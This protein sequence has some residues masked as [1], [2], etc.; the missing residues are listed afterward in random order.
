FF[1]VAVAAYLAALA[2]DEI[3]FRDLLGRIAERRFHLIA[4]SLGDGLA[5]ADK[6]G[7]ITVWNRGAAAIFGYEAA[8]MVGKP[9]DRIAA[10]RLSILDLPR[11]KLQTPGGTMMELEGRRKNGDVFALEACFSAWQGSDGL[12]FGAILRDVSAKKRELEHIRYL[13]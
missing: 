1:H 6:E 8:E 9:L 7:R 5:C 4:M 3:D 10:S 13:A 2:L 11:E 12:Q